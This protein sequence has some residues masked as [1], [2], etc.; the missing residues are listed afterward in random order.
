MKNF[1]VS[2]YSHIWSPQIYSCDQLFLLILISCM[3]VGISSEQLIL[4]LILSLRILGYQLEGSGL[5]SANWVCPSSNLL[6]SLPPLIHFKPLYFLIEVSL[7]HNVTLVSGIQHSDWTSLYIIMPCSHLSPYNTITV[8][9]CSPC[10]T[11]H[12]HDLFILRLE[13]WTSDSP[14][15]VLP[16]SPPPPL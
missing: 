12:L 14:P 8:S 9:L 10:C 5:A 4:R 3:N 6:Q 2:N 13:A 16:I 15:P 7:T 1:F 11:F